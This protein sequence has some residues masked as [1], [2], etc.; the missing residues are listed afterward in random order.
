[1]LG[2][3]QPLWQD[4]EVMCWKRQE[5]LGVVAGTLPMGLGRA[6][7]GSSPAEQESEGLNRDRTLRPKKSEGEKLREG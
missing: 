4:N 2:E 5:R 6:P 3:T 7:E 1:M